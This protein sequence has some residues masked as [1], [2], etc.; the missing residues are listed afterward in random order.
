M[1][2]AIIKLIPVLLAMYV[3]WFTIGI[4]AL[5]FQLYVYYIIGLSNLFIGILT[6]TYFGF[7]AF[8]SITSGYLVDRYG[9]A[10]LI[11]LI[12]VLI[13]GLSSIAT[14][15]YHDG[16]YLLLIRI[17][18]GLAVGAI[19]PIANLIS[20]SL[21]GPGR[22]IGIVNTFGSM[23]FASAGIIGGLSV[24]LVSYGELFIYTGIVTIIPAITLILQGGGA[25]STVENIGIRLR[26]IFS[27]PKSVWIIYLTFFLRFMA[28]GGVWTLFSLF[29]YTLGANDFMVGLAH[30]INTIT[31]VLIFHRVS[32]LSE[33][34]G[35][36][37]YKIGLLLTALTFIGYFLSP[38]I[39]Y[40]FPL[41]VLIA[42]SWV[43]LYAGANVF[44][45]ENVSEGFRGTALGALNM[46]TSFSWIAGSLINGY[47]SDV[48]GSY[49]TYILISI[50]ILLVGYLI[51]E[52]YQRYLYYGEG[53]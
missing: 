25:Y 34:R 22:G 38:N 10:R 32:I 19:I 28:A 51:V 37:V 39:Y 41:Q 47:I 15:L 2:S 44:I 49:K 14:P 13:L 43:A 29:L 52:V 26:D 35:L 5:F 1:D 18:Q 53:G 33:G 7:N 6:S 30:S 36:T 8:S 11:L 12:S 48:A 20:A 17:I 23:G 50:G 31:Q 24:E 27:L 21:I 46:F 4:Y 16:G 3:T 45:I 9:L 42:F 40:I